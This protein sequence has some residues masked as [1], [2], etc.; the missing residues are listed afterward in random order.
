MTESETSPIKSHWNYRVIR[1]LHDSPLPDEPQTETFEI[2]EVYYDESNNPV[3][4][5]AEPMYAYGESLSEL[6]DDL[7]Y[8]IRAIAQPVL[9]WEDLPHAET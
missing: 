4:W 3:A 8:M 1:R 6:T 5:T 7:Q 9:N 2:Y